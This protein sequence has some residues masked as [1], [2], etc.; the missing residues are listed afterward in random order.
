[1]AERYAAVI[2]LSRPAAGM[3]LVGGPSSIERTMADA[4]L[5]ACQCAPLDLTGKDT[6]KRLL[7]MLSRAPIIVGAR[8]R[9]DAHGQ[10]RRHQV[11]GLHASNP[12]RSSLFRP[13][14]VRE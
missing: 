10:R 8:F 6:L 1:M 4:V 12:D 9:A 7:A 3:V 11:L 5:A 2:D 13:P 14:L